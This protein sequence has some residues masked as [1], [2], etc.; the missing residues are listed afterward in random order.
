MGDGNAFA[1]V[2]EATSSAVYGFALSILQNKEDAEDVMH[3]A[4][5]KLHQN[6]GKYQPQGKPLA[7]LLTIV[8]N[9]SYNKLRDRRPHED[10]DEGK[11]LADPTAVAAS[12][13]E[14]RLLI[15]NAMRGLDESERNVI[16]L[17][18]MAGWK[19]KE[20]ANF[21][22]MPLSTVLS[23]YRRGLEKMKQAM[24]QGEIAS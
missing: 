23:K 14:N 6:A 11:T 7:W 21:L 9:L 8:K 3:D 12:D 4:Y 19:H 22:E 17:H 2:Y 24:T 10:I 20:I 5:I 13:I 18:A 16:T 1:Q 15:D